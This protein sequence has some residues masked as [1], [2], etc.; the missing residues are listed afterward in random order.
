M[1]KC[2]VPSS[3]HTWIGRGELLVASCSCFASFE[4]VVNLG[5]GGVLIYFTV[6]GRAA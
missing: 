2:Q 3:A 1:L 4:L 5:G 6:R